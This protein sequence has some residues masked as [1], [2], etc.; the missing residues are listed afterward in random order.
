VSER[1]RDGANLNGMIRTG[2]NFARVS[3]RGA[4]FHAATLMNAELRGAVHVPAVRG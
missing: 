4:S 2:I 1:V 3:L